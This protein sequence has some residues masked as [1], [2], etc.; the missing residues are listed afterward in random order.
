MRRPAATQKATEGMAQRPNSSQNIGSK[1]A[2][3]A[4]PRTMATMNVAVMM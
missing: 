2:A 3:A 4:D 1:A